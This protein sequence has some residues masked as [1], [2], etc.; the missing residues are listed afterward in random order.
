MARSEPTR[1]RKYVTARRRPKQLECSCLF[2]YH[3]L[4]KTDTNFKRLDVGSHQLQ[5]VIWLVS[6]GPMHQCISLIIIFLTN[7]LQLFLVKS[8]LHA[9]RLRQQPV[10]SVCLLAFFLTFQVEVVSQPAIRF[11]TGRILA[12]NPFVHLFGLF[13]QSPREK[14]IS[15]REEFSNCLCVAHRIGHRQHK[16]Q[17]CH[18]HPFFHCRIHTNHHPN[19]NSGKFRK[20][21]YFCI[22]QF[23][24]PQ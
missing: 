24:R 5:M 11:E 23:K 16:R 17:P 2:L 14:A 18:D 19:K 15:L 7:R 4:G 10:R 8:R 20:E 12:P 21:L 9:A 13:G 3:R 22:Q 6:Q 1:S